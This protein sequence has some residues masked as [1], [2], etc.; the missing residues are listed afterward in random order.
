MGSLYGVPG[1]WP[2]SGLALALAAFDKVN[3]VQPSSVPRAASPWPLPAPHVLWLGR[4]VG[5]LLALKPQVLGMAPLG[6]PWDLNSL[7][8]GP[9][10]QLARLSGQGL[11]QFTPTPPTERGRGGACSLWHP[12][13]TALSPVYAALR[14]GASGH[15]VDL[16][17]GGVG[18]GCAECAVGEA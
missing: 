7:T 18:A 14:A 8:L 10:P 15:D 3:L 13:G 12:H 9:Q 1:S 2:Q 16:F 17:A 4:E 5:Q 6:L 11:T